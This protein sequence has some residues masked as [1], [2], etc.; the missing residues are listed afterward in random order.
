VAIQAGAVELRD[1]ED[2]VHAS[3]KAVADRDVDQAE[4]AADRHRGLGAMA[5]EGPETAPL[6]TTEDCCD[7][8]LHGRPPD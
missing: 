2:P 7:H 8:L 4:L 3:V 5:G 6:T 1:D